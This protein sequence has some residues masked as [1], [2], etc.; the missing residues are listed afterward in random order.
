MDHLFALLV[1]AVVLGI[2]IWLL[3]PTSSS[4]AEQDD[5]NRVIDPSDPRQIGLLIG[6]AGGTLADAATARFAL[7]RFEQ[8]H[9]R[10]ATTR[11]MAL[12]VGLMLGGDRAP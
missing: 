12:V 9:G 11:E 10:K 1:G 6:M 3:V 7:E 5:G 4:S 2:V 8:I